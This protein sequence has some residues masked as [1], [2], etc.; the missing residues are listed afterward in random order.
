[1]LDARPCVHQPVHKVIF[2]FVC[3]PL[4]NLRNTR[5]CSPFDRARV[6]ARSLAINVYNADAGELV[7]RSLAAAV[8]SQLHGVFLDSLFLSRYFL[9]FRKPFGDVLQFAT[10]DRQL[11]E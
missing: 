9:Q 1:M 7:A 10:L 5:Y 6:H 3:K 4:E 2:G 11:D 8:F